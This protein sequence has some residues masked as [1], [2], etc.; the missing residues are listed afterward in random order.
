MHSTQKKTS[1]ST[2]VVWHEAPDRDSLA[3]AVADHIE[4]A[5]RA[6][7]AA[8]G[9]ASLVVPG[10]NTPVPVFK[11]L[12][13]ADLDWAHVTITLTDERWVDEDAAHSNAA[14]VRDHLL[15][16]KAVAARFVT[17]K[18]EGTGPEDT[19][20]DLARDLESVAKPFDVVMVG[21]GADGHFASLFPGAA[22][23]EGALDPAAPETVCAIVPDPLPENA[24]YPRISLTAGALLQAREVYLMATGEDKKTVLKNAEAGA[25]PVSALPIRAVLDQNRAPVTVFWSA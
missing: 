14:L 11:R 20:P 16:D 18:R 5:L 25:S 15:Q 12:A 3:A 19:L 4:A 1:A 8:R 6:G 2:N 7:L 24:P 9:E 10:G 17:L 21:M 23:V 13:Q 22:G